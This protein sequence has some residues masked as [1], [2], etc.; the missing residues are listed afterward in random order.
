MK[1]PA[2]LATIGLAEAAGHFLSLSWGFLVIMAA[3]I[4]VGLHAASTAT[5]A[6]TTEQRLNSH[7]A[8]TAGAVALVANGG[9]ISGDLTITGS[10]TVDTNLGVHGGSTLVGDSSCS[11]NWTA[12]T[13]TSTASTTVD[14]NLGV[15]GNSSLLG[16]LSVEGGIMPQNEPSGVSAP[17]NGTGG[18]SQYAG[19]F[20]TGSGASTWAIAL[21]NAH[22]SLLTTLVNAG[23][24][25]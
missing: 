13:L 17:P 7:I 25:H 20:F 5:K 19:N 23:V 16:S 22:N 15:H 18:P 24:L 4:Y 1:W 11:G 14:G 12:S 21:T 6:V 8:A 9:T 10:C 2:M 3:F